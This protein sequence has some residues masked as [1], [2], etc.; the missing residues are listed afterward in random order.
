MYLSHCRRVRVLSLRR[1]NDGGGARF[2]C[3]RV[4]GYSFLTC[5]ATTTTITT[6]TTIT[7]TTT[8]TPINNT[9]TTT[10]TGTAATATAT[11]TTIITTYCCSSDE[12][13]CVLDETY[14]RETDTT[15]CQPSRYFSNR[16]AEYRQARTRPPT[17]QTASAGV[18]CQKPRIVTVSTLST[19]IDYSR[20][21]INLPHSWLISRR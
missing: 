10:A 17:D 21:I 9:I 3:V 6:I 1:R 11:S 2:L 18:Q 4:T 13:P 14:D 20:S 15:W 8:T 12:C 16:S 19:A 5:C 7:T